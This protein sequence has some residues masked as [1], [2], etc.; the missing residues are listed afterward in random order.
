MSPRTPPLFVLRRRIYLIISSFSLL[1]SVIG[2][3]I[4][5]NIVEPVSHGLVTGIL[6]ASA[7]YHGSVIVLILTRRIRLDL[8]RVPLIVMTAV[9]IFTLLGHALYVD[10]P[11]KV[12]QLTLSG[13]YIWLPILHLFTFLALEARRALRLS[14]GL[15]GFTLLFTLPHAVQ[16]LPGT[17][18][19]DGFSA[20][21][22]IYLSHAVTITGLYFLATYQSYLRQAEGKA[23]VLKRLAYTDALTGIANRR[24]MELVISNEVLREQRYGRPFSIILVDIDNFKTVN[25]NYGHDVGD[26]VLQDLAETLQSRI[27]ASDH[28]GRWGGEEF[29]V[30]TPETELKEACALA[31]YICE[32]VRTVALL[33]AHPL[34]LSLG[35]A[36]FQADDSVTS[37]V[38]RADEAL[39]AAKQGG[40]NQVV[41]KGKKDKTLY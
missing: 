34:T 22:N 15:F 8:V 19:F 24:Q 23:D 41:S 10:Y 25:D 7:S 12:S 16:T 36:S 37:L 1:T 32:H 18:V 2:I 4:Y 5:L 3:V 31:E 11:S 28:V 26:S 17:D 30:V 9:V 35:V 39:Y 20:L 29:V 40:K 6:I 14:L 13:M 21:G 38:K 33:K 27:R